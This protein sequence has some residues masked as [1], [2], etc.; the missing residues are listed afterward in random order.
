MMEWPKIEGE[1]A[2]KDFSKR[3]YVV[4]DYYSKY[5][6]LEINWEVLDPRDKLLES[7]TIACSV[8]E[9]SLK[10]VGE[11]SWKIP[12][13]ANGN[14]KIRLELSEPMKLLSS[15]EYIIKVRLNR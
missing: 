7:K 4:N 6:S 10:E 12:E 5:P 14:Y 15:N 2:G 8:S 1:Q 9:N 11:V 3:V 13:R